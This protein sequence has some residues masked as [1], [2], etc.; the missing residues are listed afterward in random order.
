MAIK[1]IQGTP[2]CESDSNPSGEEL[3]N[4]FNNNLPTF[5]FNANVPISPQKAAS[6]L[7]KQ[8]PDHFENN[9][10]DVSKLDTNKKIEDYKNKNNLKLN[11]KPDLGESFDAATRKDELV[12]EY[13]NQVANQQPDEDE[14]FRPSKQEVLNACKKRDS[15]DSESNESEANQE[16]SNN[17]FSPTINEILETCKQLPSEVPVEY[18]QPNLPVPT[19]FSQREQDQINDLMNKM[20]LPNEEDEKQ[21]EK[22]KNE[23]EKISKDIRQK[24]DQYQKDLERFPNLEH[25]YFVK[26]L[27]YQILKGKADVIQNY[28]DSQSGNNK[29]FNISY[30]PYINDPNNIEADEAN[31]PSESVDFDRLVSQENQYLQNEVDKFAGRFIEFGLRPE[32]TDFRK[33]KLFEKRTIGGNIAEFYDNIDAGTEEERKEKDYNEKRKKRENER[34]QKLIYDPFEKLKTQA[35]NYGALFG[36]RFIVFSQVFGSSGLSD[37]ITEFNEFEQ[38]YTSKKQEYEKLKKKI[39]NFEQT[40]K[41]DVNLQIEQVKCR[42]NQKNKTGDEEPSEDELNKSFDLEDASFPS[43]EDSPPTELK[44]WQKF[45]LSATVGSLIVPLTWT[46]GVLIPSPSGVIKV[47]VPVIWTALFVQPTPNRLLVFFLGINGIIP[48]PFLFEISFSG[49]SA[50]IF[51]VGLRGNN[52]SIKSKAPIGAGGEV[53]TIPAQFPPFVAYT[54][55]VLCTGF[56]FTKL[57]NIDLRPVVFALAS[58]P[59]LTPA[60]LAKFATNKAAIKTNIFARDDLP[61]YKRLPGSNPLK[62]PVFYF[63]VAGFN[64]ASKELSG[65]EKPPSPAPYQ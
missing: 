21:A 45:A 34:K 23:I 57:Q 53:Q 59:F 26:E 2:Y 50:P 56:S 12:E 22:C 36:I 25:E 58:S 10:T 51:R 64:E 61:S 4:I 49:G 29:S 65:V 60:K 27:N 39:E 28:L 14:P 8:N 42:Q 52:Q 24:V 3:R 43:P 7:V 33:F 47:P 1:F 11:V 32:S 17:D 19:D 15:S 37:A 48:C 63:F 31:D 6:E 13:F 16:N 46:T 40:I 20:N 9:E 35:N 41:N 55:P 44:Y 5:D 18:P 54:P 38:S 62:N 30:V